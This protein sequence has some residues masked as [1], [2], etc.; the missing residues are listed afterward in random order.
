MAR[1]PTLKR[2]LTRFARSRLADAALGG[3]A[4]LLGCSGARP[5]PAVPGSANVVLSKE[6]PPASYAELQPLSVQS[7]KGC[8]VFGEGGSR[9]AAEAKLRDAAQR[10]GATYVRITDEQAPRPNHACL[11][12]EYKLSGVA[13]RS[14]SAE[15]A[16]P[17]APLQTP[18][19]ERLCTPGATQACL[20]PGACQ[21]AQACRD[22]ASGFLPCDCGTPAAPSPPTAPASSSP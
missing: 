10:L 14:A 12:H 15:S 21:G 5:E 7:G 18:K 17:A 13:Y 8:G 20:G 2:R 3:L 9:E 6:A 4:A 19:L 11:E 16:P 22:D 1:N